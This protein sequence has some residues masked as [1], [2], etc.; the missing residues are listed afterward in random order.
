VLFNPAPARKLSDEFLSKIDVFTPN[1]TECELITGMSVK[2]IEEAKAAVSF[3]R[4]KG[5]P[6][7]IVTM[8]SRGVVYNAGKEICHKPVPK[9]QVVDT[10]AAGDSFSGAIAVALSCG[11]G[12]HDAIDFANAVGTL[13][14]TKKGAQISLPTIDD[15]NRYMGLL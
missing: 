8:G 1:E 3:L 9:V 4:A 5:I 10:T 7:V 13:T 12:I 11:K 15:V 6:Q 2:S 14:V